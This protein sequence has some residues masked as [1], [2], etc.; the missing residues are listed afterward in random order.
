[1]IPFKFFCNFFYSNFFR[2]K[3][4][5][6]FFHILFTKLTRRKFC[7]FFLRRFIF[8]A[9]KSF[10]LNQTNYRFFYLST[11]VSQLHKLH[12][13][14]ILSKLN[15]LLLEMSN[16]FCCLHVAASML[17]WKHF[18]WSSKLAE[19]NKKERSTNTVTLKES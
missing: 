8:S 16:L 13:L 4:Q 7:R 11:H 10:L 3:N 12:G 5:I 17:N 9:I 19:K 2:K 1:M 6:N 18:F 15:F 14:L